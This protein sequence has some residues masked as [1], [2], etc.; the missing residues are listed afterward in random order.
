[1][2][3]REN[4]FARQC[5]GSANLHRPACNAC[6]MNSHTQCEICLSVLSGSAR[7][8]LTGCRAGSECRANSWRARRKPRLHALNT[9]RAGGA[10]RISISRGGAEDAEKRII[11]SRSQNPQ[12]SQRLCENQSTDVDPAVNAEQTPGRRVVREAE[13]DFL[14]LR[15]NGRGMANQ[16]PRMYLRDTN[17]TQAQ[18]IPFIIRAGMNF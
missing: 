8:Q 11:G 10:V 14:Y 2:A 3:L 15:Y 13:I 12:R 17:R 6:G 5:R 16:K 7:N 4:P 9:F 18:R 1:M